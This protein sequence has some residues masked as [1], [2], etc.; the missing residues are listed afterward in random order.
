LRSLIRQAAHLATEDNSLRQAAI[1]QATRILDDEFSYDQLSIAIA[2]EI[3]RLIIEVTGNS[4]PY[5]VRKE[6]EMRLARKVYS[7]VPSQG[8]TARRTLAARNGAPCDPCSDELGAYVKLAAAANSLDFFREASAAAE[9]IRKPVSFVVDDSARLEA[10]L[11]S[12]DC[13]LYL[14]DNAGEI[15][16][17]LPLV[18]LMRRSARV[19]YAVKPSPVQNDLTLDDVR[20][21][22]L[23]GELGEVIST[24]IASPGVV[25][26]LASARFRREFDAADLV[27]AKGMGHYEAL[28]EL[29][30]Q[31]RV[32]HC[33]MAKCKPVAASLEVPVNT[34]VAMLR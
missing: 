8:T 31:G 17:D 13:I 5:R 24:G 16:F 30:P 11:R 25:F 4:D 23:E 15:Y 2:T 19:I 10:K 29:P 18:K 6:Q 22:G 27:F 3:H 1:S 20:R 9:D 14:A 7:E 32:F 26:S 28:S 12:A 21:S 34:Y 33:L